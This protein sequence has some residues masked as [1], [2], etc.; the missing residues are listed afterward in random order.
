MIIANSFTESPK[1]LQLFR[2]FELTT[3]AS[4]VSA[5]KS[6]VYKHI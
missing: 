1:K 4:N 2:A 6:L 5:A 3:K